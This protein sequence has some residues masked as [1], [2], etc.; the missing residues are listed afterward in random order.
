[1]L[2]ILIYTWTKI[3]IILEILKNKSIR[4]EMKTIKGLKLKIKS[5]RAEM[6]ITFINI[7]N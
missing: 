2:N 1:M 7:F 6:K 3:W 4:A 5:L